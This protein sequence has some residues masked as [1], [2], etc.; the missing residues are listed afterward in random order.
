MSLGL[1]EFGSRGAAAEARG[2][3][4]AVQV[5]GAVVLTYALWTAA[6][7]GLAASA[8]DRSGG[9]ARAEVASLSQTSESARRTLAKH[10]DLLI[11]TASVESSPERILEDLREV[12][13]EGVT[14][15]SLK[16]EYLADASTR[17]DMGVEARGPE[18]YDR[19]LGALSKS[20][21]FTDIKPGSESR[22]G[23]VRAT[24]S[25][26]HRPGGSGR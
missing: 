8:A 23:L 19:F 22:P 6:S 14:V 4:R 13:P 24:V 18:A 3:W 5:V 2:R 21:R 15:V 9:K 26:S 16:V 25:A 1:P 17:L 10:S 20:P 12:L 11:A 7:E